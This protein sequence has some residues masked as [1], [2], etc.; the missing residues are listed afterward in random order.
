MSGDFFKKFQPHKGKK[1]TQGGFFQV[2]VDDQELIAAM[3]KVSAD[4]PDIIHDTLQKR[5]NQQVGQMKKWLK[6]EAGPLANVTIPADP[7]HGF[8]E[9]SKHAYVK[10]AE[11]LIGYDY[12]KMGFLVGSQPFMEGVKGS[13]GVRLA[14]LHYEGKTS[15]K[16]PNALPEVVRSSTR[17]WKMG[18]HARSGDMGKHSFM[19]APFSTSSKLGNHPGF[20]SK[21]FLTPIY[22][23][24]I[25]NFARDWVDKILSRYP[26]AEAIHGASSIVYATMKN[27]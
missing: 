1:E 18:S 27:R 13:R 17:F 12:K 11:S 16:Y 9:P 25:E 3:K 14:Q 19:G 4:M 22:D 5:I 24:L 7:E 8:P 26:G 15:F 21:D 23:G 6:K 2:H 20:D 10:I